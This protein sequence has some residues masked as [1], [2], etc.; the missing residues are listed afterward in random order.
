MTEHNTAAAS[1]WEMP[2]TEAIRRYAETDFV[3]LDVP[4]HCG[5]A[6]AQPELAEVFGEQVLRLDLPPLVDGIDQGPAPTALQPQA[7]A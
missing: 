5:S 7:A 6:A 3:R 4:G 1:Q 2:Y